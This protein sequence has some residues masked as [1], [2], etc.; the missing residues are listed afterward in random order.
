MSL[1]LS[2]P[3]PTAQAPFL[4]WNSVSTLGL[5]LVLLIAL[6]ATGCSYW[7]KPSGEKFG[8]SQAEVA[9]D[10]IS[11]DVLVAQLTEDKFE[12]FNEV[13]KS[14][15]T[16]KIDLQTRKKLDANGIRAGILPSA[17][18]LKI[19]KLFE[20]SEIR[21]EE[22]DSWQQRV[23]D[24]G[25]LRRESPVKLFKRIQNQAGSEHLIQV[26][27]TWPQQSWVVHGTDER[28][29][30]VGEQVEAAFEL[31]T[32]PSRDGSLKL[33]LIPQI[34][35]GLARPQFDV[36]G[37]QFLLKSKKAELALNELTIR[38][39]L[40]PGETLIVAATSDFSDLGRLFFRPGQPLLLQDLRVR[41]E[42][43]K[44]EVPVREQKLLAIQLKD[45]ATR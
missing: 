18:G 45:V 3:Q 14:V 7:K 12:D 43:S 39:A 44:L 24:K 26:S 11:L 27:D 23:H 34:L 38:L 29:V 31:T 16:L 4:R 6:V 21:A 32:F 10:A 37:D 19:R 9:T 28:I 2:S 41:D 15:D 1:E 5:P 36:E 30:G 33:Q 13:W 8:L 20:A 25:L 35:H 40:Q 42:N 22:L 17:Q